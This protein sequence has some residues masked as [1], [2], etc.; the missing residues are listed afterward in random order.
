MTT[1]TATSFANA[2]RALSHPDNPLTHH[3]GTS[4]E[5]DALVLLTTE[6]DLA[7]NRLASAIGVSRAAMTACADR[8]ETMELAERVPDATDRR[9]VFLRI[10]DEGK[11]LVED[12]FAFDA[13]LV[14]A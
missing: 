8:L 12:G 14:A 1:L 5:R 4:S 2:I 11:Q 3:L 6:G 7:L 13:A 9:R 10:T